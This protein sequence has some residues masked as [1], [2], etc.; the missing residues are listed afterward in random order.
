VDPAGLL[1]LA[2]FAWIDKFKMTGLWR[3]LFSWAYQVVERKPETPAVAKEQNG[4]QYGQHKQNYLNFRV[5]SVQDNNRNDKGRNDQR[6]GYDNVEIDR[7]DEITLLALVN[8]PAIRTA[9]PGLE[10]GFENR[11]VT[12]IWTAQ[13]QR[14]KQ[15]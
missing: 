12:A 10:T 5:E 6:F 3:I 11:T 8:Q 7:T 4:H 14:S 13:A 1:V 9:F 2:V 15:G